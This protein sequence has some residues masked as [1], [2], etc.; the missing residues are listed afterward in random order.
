MTHQRG[1]TLVEALVA[2]GILALA[3]VALYGAM[4]TSLSGL[5]RAT[6]TDEAILV[7]EARLAELA[8]LRQLPP[9]LEGAVEGKAYSWRI[10]VLPDPEAEPDALKFSS[11][12]AQRIKLTIL[13]RENGAP[14]QIAV[15]RRLLVWRAPGG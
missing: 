14:R 1:F 4:G 10:E 9:V 7:A 5:A 2:F 12:R 8:A 3:L 6:R 15:E 11:L 13:W